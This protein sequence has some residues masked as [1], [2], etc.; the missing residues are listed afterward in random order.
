[1]DNE[2]RNEI[3]KTARDRYYTIAN[4]S[5]GE[6]F[7]GV[8]LLMYHLTTDGLK[9][10]VVEIP[11]EHK[12]STDIG[13]LL[14]GAL[15]DIADRTA[16]K[17]LEKTVYSIMGAIPRNELSDNLFSEQIEAEEYTE[18]D[19]GFVLP[20]LIDNICIIEVED[21]EDPHERTSSSRGDYGP[22]NPWN[23]PGMSVR[24]FI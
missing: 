1:M 22:S 23:A 19:L 15:H 13:G 2:I 7:D 5:C 8:A 10:H 14:E 17:Y 11:K 24:D 9:Y 6:Y 16:P 21:E 3:I 20:G 18:L 12:D 4:G